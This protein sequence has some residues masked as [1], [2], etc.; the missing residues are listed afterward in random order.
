MNP[1]ALG[2]AWPVD[3]LVMVK[4]ADTELNYLKE[5]DLSRQAVLQSGQ[6]PNDFIPSIHRQ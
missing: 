3:S 5:L 6:L 4:D 2:I 1:Q